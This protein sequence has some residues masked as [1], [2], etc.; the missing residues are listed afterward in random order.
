[1]NISIFVAP[2]FIAAFL[3]HAVP[4]N[5]VEVLDCDDAVGRQDNIVSA[6]LDQLKD[7]AVLFVVSRVGFGEKSTNLSAQRLYNLRQYFKDRG[8]RLQSN[9]VLIVTGDPIQNYGS[10]QY[11]INGILYDELRYPRNGFLCHECCGP[12]NQY[13]PK[14]RNTKSLEE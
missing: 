7:G 13:Y 11:Y 5:P 10:V 2:L 12:Q 6:T 3:T 14:V 4:Q 9:Q 1:M 8:N